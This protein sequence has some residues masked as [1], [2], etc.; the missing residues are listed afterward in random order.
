MLVSHD[1]D[2]NMV[3]ALGDD[4]YGEKHYSL[5]LGQAPPR[6]A[7]TVKCHFCHILNP[8]SLSGPRPGAP[9]RKVYLEFCGGPGGHGGS[10]E[11]RMI[12][13]PCFIGD[14][15]VATAVRASCSPHDW[16]GTTSLRCSIIR[17]SSSSISSRSARLASSFHLRQRGKEEDDDDDDQK[18]KKKRSHSRDT[19]QKKE[20][21]EEGKRS[22]SFVISGDV[23]IIIY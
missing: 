16:C 4:S 2:F 15:A 19:P 11:K 3:R 21:E 20:E 13:L 5:V 10:Q 7:C 6:L 1:I 14:T 17:V 8:I 12:C 18:K 23:I 9:M 22:A